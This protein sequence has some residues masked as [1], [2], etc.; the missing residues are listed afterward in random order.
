MQQNSTESQW[1][2]DLMDEVKWEPTSVRAGSTLVGCQDGTSNSALL[3]HLLILAGSNL[4]LLC[5]VSYLVISNYSLNC[6]M[7]E[8]S[9]N[10][11]RS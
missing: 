2:E 5:V 8:K 6:D 9:F 4:A 7:G 3:T 10:S 1:V 11:S